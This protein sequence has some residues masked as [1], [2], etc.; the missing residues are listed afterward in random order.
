M[1]NETHPSPLLGY[2]AGA[3]SLVLVVAGLKLA[4]QIVNLVLISVLL[5]FSISPVQDWLIR[6][7]VPKGLAVF[8]TVLLAFVGG[9][10]LLSILTVSV[11]GLIGE[12]PNYEAKLTSLWN[13]V[14]TFFLDHH[15]NISG[16]L[17]VKE[18]DPKQLA[19]VAGNVLGTVLQGMSNG[20][21]VII[22]MVFALVEMSAMQ[23]RSFRDTSAR[24]RLQDH[25]DQVV[26]DVGKYIAITGGFGLINA[27]ANFLWL[28]V[29]GVDFALTWAVISFLFTFIPNF[30]FVMAII[31]PAGIALLKYGWLR[32]LLVIAGYGV[33]NFIV[34][35]VIK[36]RAMK[37]RLDIS[38]LLTIL[39][40]IF[41]GWVLGAPGVVLGVPLTI[42]LQKLAKEQVSQ[43]C[44]S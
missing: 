24:T 25:V 10:G 37:S 15:L 44:L 42:T 35:N 18:F 32:A 41:W 43:G 19:A 5:A 26:K 17:S 21:F 34:D 12:L 13:A 40:V 11:G 9:L 27:A 14:N 38:P 23:L 3:A 6:K 1:T 8:G 4:A 16:L 20:V 33:L 28:L 22:V 39:S 31:P 30:G 2:L 36:P 7:K 29:L